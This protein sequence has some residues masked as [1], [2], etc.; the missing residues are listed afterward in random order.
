MSIAPHL[1]GA[2]VVLLAVVT[3]N[4]FLVNLTGNAQLAVWLTA[5]ILGIFAY[6]SLSRAMR[7]TGY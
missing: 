1:G 4:M 6:V 5:I 7:S 2:A 3:A